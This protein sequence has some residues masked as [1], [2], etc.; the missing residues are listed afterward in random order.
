MIA[1][2]RPA[3]ANSLWAA[4]AG[5]PPDCPP[6]DG[7]ALAEVAIVGGGYTGLS[8]ALHLAGR[9]VSVMLL[10]A[11]SPGWGASGR[12]GGQVNPGLKEAP[13]EV[14]RRLGTEAGARLA[15]FAGTAADLVFDL[16]ATHGID[17]A[18]H[19][20]GW[21]RA[22]PNPHTLDALKAQAE[23]WQCRGAR[24]EVLDRAETARL[25]GT[26]AYKGGLIDRRGGNLHPLNYALGLAHAAQAAGAR[27]HGSS[28]VT[29]ITPHGDGYRL[30]T[31]NGALDAGRVLLCTNGYTDALWP[32]LAQSVVPVV[33]VQVATEPLPA[34]VAGTILPEGHSPSDLRRL[35]LYWRRAPDGRFVMGGRGAWREGGLLRTQAALRRAAGALYPALRGVR[36]DFAWGGQ[37]AITADHLPHLHRLGAGVMAALGYNGRGVALATAMGAELAAWAAGT[38]ARDLALPVTPLSPVPFHR[39]HRLGVAVAGA[40]AAALDRLGV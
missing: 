3:L 24:V 36:W 6:L 21:L 1:N 12:N 35:L 22:A 15:G 40:R 9:G 29:A 27:L 28:C 4:T 18:A 19:R 26:T 34:G 5:P 30:T 23:D 20:P 38:P 16:I 32:G 13:A 37:V 2:E 14:E 10:E 33:S 11:E 7:T 17:C 25:L 31:A 8:A 39:F